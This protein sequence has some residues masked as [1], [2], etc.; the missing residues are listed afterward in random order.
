M[1]INRKLAFPDLP[2]TGHIANIAESTRMTQRTPRPV[3]NQHVL[4]ITASL[5]Y[6]LVDAQKERLGDGQAER[7]GG[8][9]IDDEI[10]F[11]R[12]LDRDVGRLRPA[13]NLVDIVGGA[14]EQ[15]REVWPIGHQTSRFD[16]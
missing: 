1:L 14:P 6:D 13:Q 10:E 12:L 4:N 9:Q 8:R 11:G 5:F 16:V 15:V 7:L 2:L 3:L